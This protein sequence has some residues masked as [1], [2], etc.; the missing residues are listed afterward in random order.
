M[1]YVL[2][3]HVIVYGTLHNN[4][5]KACEYKCKFLHIIMSQSAYKATYVRLG[6]AN[7]VSLR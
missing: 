2:L 5:C 4:L 3:I 1:L 6:V 7:V